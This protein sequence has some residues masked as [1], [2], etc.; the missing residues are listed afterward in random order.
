[1]TENSKISTY[2]LEATEQLKNALE[3]VKEKYNGELPESASESY[4]NL[5]EQM[6][7]EVEYY[8]ENS[9]EYVD[10]NAE[11][12]VLEGVFKE[13]EDTLSEYK[14]ETD[15][16]SDSVQTASE[17]LEN[18]DPEE[19]LSVDEFRERISDID[20]DLDRYSD[21]GLDSD[22]VEDTRVTLSDNRKKTVS[23]LA[24]LVIL[25]A[26]YRLLRKQS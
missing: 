20:Y 15:D 9:S 26:V 21:H 2:R 11:V 7:D 5:I 17:Y 25:Y 13:L 23:G 24:I 19:T 10:Q 4:N 22:A 16:Y 8:V 12:P 6:I 14:E 18:L 1:M 3:E